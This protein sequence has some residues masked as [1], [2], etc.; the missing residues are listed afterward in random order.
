MDSSTFTCFKGGS[1]NDFLSRRRFNESTFTNIDG[2]DSIA[3]L[4]LII[5][6]SNFRAI[7]SDSSPIRY[8]A[9][10]DTTE[11]LDTLRSR[12]LVYNGAEP[13]I[14][15]YWFD[16]FNA[17][18]LG[19]SLKDGGSGEVFLSKKNIMYGVDR[20]VA[21]LDNGKGYIWHE[22]KWGK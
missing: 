17:E 3:Y 19:L 9:C 16:C 6:Y 7:S 14:A 22:I 8:R 13:R 12:Y 11:D 5:N 2:C 4:D 15:P 10:F 1:K 18:E 20:V 21:I